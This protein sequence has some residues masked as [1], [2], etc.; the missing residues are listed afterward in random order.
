MIQIASG[1]GFQFDYFKTFETI[2]K[3]HGLWNITNRPLS[4]SG[5]IDGNTLTKSYNCVTAGVKMID[6]GVI[7]PITKKLINI[8]ITAENTDNYALT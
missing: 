6:I 1:E 4:L 2:L 5:S 7:C 8:N 3:H